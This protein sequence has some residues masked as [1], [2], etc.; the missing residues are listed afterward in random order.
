MLFV[1]FFLYEPI[2]IGLAGGTIGHYLMKLR[3]KQAGD[4]SKNILLPLCFFRS[5]VKATL[6]WISFL[7]MGFNTQRRAI[8]DFASGAVVIE[9]E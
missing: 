4:H 5:L 6:N 8:H 3:V 1:M 9:M 7:T 2:L